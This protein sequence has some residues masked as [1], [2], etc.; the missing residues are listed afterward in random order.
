VSKYLNVAAAIIVLGLPAMGSA[1]ARALNHNHPY[2]GA[3]TSPLRMN[4][5]PSISRM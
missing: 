4:S 3:N 2:H 5:M 1:N